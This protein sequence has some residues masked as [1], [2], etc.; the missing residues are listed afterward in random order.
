MVMTRQADWRLLDDDALL[1]RRI[2][3]FALR[4][5]GTPMDPC[6][7]QLHEELAARGLALDRALAGF[8]FIA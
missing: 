1:E 2:N 7:A 8:D 5:E 3:T 4:I 6:V